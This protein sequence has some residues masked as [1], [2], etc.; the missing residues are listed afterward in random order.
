MSKDNAGSFL[1]APPPA[2]SFNGD[3]G[4][5]SAETF[6]QTSRRAATLGE[7]LGESTNA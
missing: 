7:A 2:M 4:C 1:L 3:R 6:A 5:T